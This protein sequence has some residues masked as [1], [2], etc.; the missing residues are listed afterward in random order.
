MQ[1]LDF[2]KKQLRWVH[3]NKNWPTFMSILLLQPHMQYFIKYIYQN[4]KKKVKSNLLKH[5]V[6]FTDSGSF[7]ISG[8][9]LAASSELESPLEIS[10]PASLPPKQIN[11]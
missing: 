5:K 4:N 2:T 11:L 6:T 1:K 10:L 8:L 9:I 3:T 7:L